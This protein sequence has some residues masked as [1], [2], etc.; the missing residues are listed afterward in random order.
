MVVY[1]N[2]SIAALNH[3]PY[4]EIRQAE[5]TLYDENED[6]DLQI[7][8]IFKSVPL[9]FE[10][11]DLDGDGEIEKKEIE[12]IRKNFMDEKR[13]IFGPFTK[14]HAIRLQNRLDAMD[15]NRDEEITLKEF[16]TYF[17]KRISEMDADN[18]KIITVDEYRTDTENIREY[19]D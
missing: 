16:E 1:S 3:I 18:D 15:T 19:Y 17:K 2:A 5:M 14:R 11:Y 9:K 12:K 4:D 10:E 8:E 13:E 6:G 7:E